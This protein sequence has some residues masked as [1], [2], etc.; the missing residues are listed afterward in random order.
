MS[1]DESAYSDAERK[2]KGD[3][4]ANFLKNRQQMKMSELDEQLAEYIAEWRKQ[5]QKE[6]DELNKLKEK[7]AKRKILRAEE[8]KKLTEQKKAEEDRK[9]REEAERKAQE[10]EAKRKRLEEVE[11]KRQAM[12]KPSDGVKKFGTKSGDKLSNIQAAK[13]EL[14][15]TR[16]QLAEE[17]KIAMSIRVQPLNLDGM[18]PSQLR[19]KAEQMWALIIKLE[20][21]KY[22]ME[23]RMKRQDYD[24]KELRERQKQ[25][26][27]QKALKKGLDPEAL[28]GKHPPKIQTAS[29]FERRTD[30]RTYDDKKKLFEGG[31]DDVH[32][33]DLE[34][35]WQ[36]HYQEFMSR[37][38]TRLPKWFGERPGRKGE[39]GEDTPEGEEEDI[40]PPPPPPPPME[41]E[42]EEE[43]EEESE[44]EEEEEEE[45]DEE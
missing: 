40:E 29:K 24:L 44:E 36:E 9:M 38:I 13:G 16:E 41:E 30:R 37:T 17:K 27:R 33:E 35:M 19:A 31:W 6:E 43:S 25:Q 18:Q 4:G 20:T 5:R 45:E 21:E 26:L 15:K 8:E 7:Q 1:D 14:G 34:K 2:K 42:P 10:Q 39:K 32:K 11:K 3:E 23:E 12:M 22:D 28:T